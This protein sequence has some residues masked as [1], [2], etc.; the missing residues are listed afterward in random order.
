MLIA[1]GNQDNRNLNMFFISLKKY[2]FI[3][4]CA[5]SSLLHGLSLAVASGG[6]SLVAM[7]RGHS[8]CRGQSLQLPNKASLVGEHGLQ[9]TGSVVAAHGLSCHLACGIFQTRDRTHVHSSCQAD[10]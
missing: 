9:S 2:F 3:F 5:G 8:H 6:Y 10:S 4:D 1:N 7:G